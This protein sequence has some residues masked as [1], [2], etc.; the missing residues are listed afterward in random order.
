MSLVVAAGVYCELQPIQPALKTLDSQIDLID[1][2]VTP[3]QFKVLSE[4]LL[5]SPQR[6]VILLYNDLPAVLQQAIGLTPDKDVDE[7][8]TEWC[9][10]A[11]LLQRF[12][13]QHREQTLLF[14]TQDILNHPQDFLDICAEQWGIQNRGPLELSLLSD[15]AVCDTV[16]FWL[17][18]QKEQQNFV[19]QQTRQYMRAL[20]WPLAQ[21]IN[22]DVF[23]IDETQV[24]AGWRLYYALEKTNQEKLAR[25]Q[26]ERDQFA[27]SQNQLKLELSQLR[28]DYN[29]RQT[30]LDALR[31]EQEQAQVELAQLRKLHDQQQ[32]E[33]KDK[34]EKITVLSQNT[35]TEKKSL[36][37]EN[38]AL[39]EQVH[40]TQE[41]FERIFIEKNELLKNIS[42]LNKKLDQLRLVDKENKRLTELLHSTQE[43]LERYHQ[44]AIKEKDVTP[45]SQTQGSAQSNDKKPGT[46]LMV[47]PTPVASQVVPTG[48]FE[49]RQYKKEKRKAYRIAVERAAL[50]EQ[51]PWFD[52][53]WYLSQYQDI[54][55]DAVQSKN[56]ALHYMRQGGFEGRNPS[57]HFDSAFYLESNPDVAQAKI[58]PLWHFLKSGQAEGRQPYP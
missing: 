5:E 16:F 43:E 13:R 6:R 27:T 40:T 46:A 33:L 12:Y 19:L 25:M 54:A 4:S 22:E 34:T 52:K 2:V 1:L 15:Q 55:A 20:T 21:E 38:Q 57:P 49:R 29:Q 53:A 44:Q 17:A 37:Q 11:E 56:P 48:F 42:A 14:D 32:K 8:I 10:N 51:S 23:L 41:E 35:T 26:N 9:L 36:A 18:Q 28:K 31:K 30:E 50:I 39:L 24:L 3:D 45:T 7:V 47:V 58:N